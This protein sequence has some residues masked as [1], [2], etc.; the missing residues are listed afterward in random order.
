MTDDIK[1]LLD[2]ASSASPLKAFDIDTV[3]R[4]GR[5][6][7]RRRRL[8]LAGGGLFGVA[9]LTA[10]TIGLSSVIAPQTGAAPEQVG[11]TQPPA[12]TYT[13]P[14]LDPAKKY[15]WRSYDWKSQPRVDDATAAELTDAL[16]SY[17]AEHFPQLKVI[18]YGPEEE[19]FT[20]PDGSSYPRAKAK[21]VAPDDEQSPFRVSRY[22]NRLVTEGG[23]IVHEQPVYRVRYASEAANGDTLDFL[24]GAEIAVD[25]SGV[26]QT[27]LLRVALYP[28][29]GFRIGYDPSQ[30]GWRD[31]V[32]GYLIKGCDTYDVTDAHEGT[33]DDRRFSFD[34]TES[35]GPNGERILAVA[36]HETYLDAD[37]TSTINTVVVYRTDGTAVV[38]GDTPRPGL[39]WRQGQPAPE[40]P[41]LTIEALT[42]L[43]L[44]VPIV[45]IG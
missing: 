14:E 22:T 35:T 31:P 19:L 30:D 28:A 7:A 16:R 24:S 21:L 4:R 18:Q 43:A 25:G 29:G 39:N 15:Y 3:V 11:G 44:A 17:L 37:V 34:C 5:G 42:G 45:P 9:A 10:A 12:K 6:R 23:Q 8:G 32:N 40:T 1:V 41:G 20:N 27:D 36:F 2:H 38:V 26:D 33:T 13:L